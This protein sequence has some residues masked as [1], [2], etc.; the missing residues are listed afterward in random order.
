MLPRLLLLFLL[1]FAAFCCSL[2]LFAALCCSLL[3]FAAVVPAAPSPSISLGD[4]PDT[5][6]CIG[7]NSLSID[8]IF[9]GS[10]FKCLL[11]YS[12]QDPDPSNMPEDLTKSWTLAWICAWFPSTSPMELGYE[13]TILM[14]SLAFWPYS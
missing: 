10:F 4:L 1:L 6:W 12:K 7:S 3:L 5:L 2:L 13:P 9:Q 14:Q 11:D 8:S